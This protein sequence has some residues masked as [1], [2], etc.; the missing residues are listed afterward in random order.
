MHE[1][2]Q[3]LHKILASQE[4]SAWETSHDA[5]WVFW[6]TLRCQGHSLGTTALKHLFKHTLMIYHEER[7][8]TWLWSPLFTM[9]T[10]KSLV[11]VFASL[12][13]IRRQL[14]NPSPA[15]LPTSSWYTPCHCLASDSTF[16]QRGELREQ[17]MTTSWTGTYY[18]VDIH[19]TGINQIFTSIF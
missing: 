3:E 6:G 2:S 7:P 16:R 4:G 15:T 10:N 5:L 17:R 1:I 11:R 14:P 19:S 9:S 18:K 12:W 13:I 8:H